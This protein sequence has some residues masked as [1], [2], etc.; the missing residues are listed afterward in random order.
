MCLISDKLENARRKVAACSL[1]IHTGFPLEQCSLHFSRLCGR[2]VELPG[3]HH[4]LVTYLYIKIHM[5]SWLKFIIQ[6]MTKLLKTPQLQ[7][8]QFFGVPFQ[9]LAHSSTSTSATVSQVRILCW[10][11][12][13]PQNHYTKVKLYNT[14]DLSR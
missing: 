14:T 9:D 12:T 13:G 1:W 5:Q 11:M 6:E 10:V 8:F 3:S 7:N 4:K 2:I